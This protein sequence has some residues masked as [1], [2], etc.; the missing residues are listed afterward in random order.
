MRLIERQ[1]YFPKADIERINKSSTIAFLIVLL[2]RLREILRC[3]PAGELAWSLFI[4]AEGY[5]STE[6]DHA[7]AGGYSL[8]AAETRTGS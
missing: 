1:S 6:P 7:E 8:I 3:G 2:L 4:F 5:E